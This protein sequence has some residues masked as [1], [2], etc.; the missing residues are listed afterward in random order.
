M[1]EVAIASG[2]AVIPRT[3]GRGWGDVEG[4]RANDHEVLRS[5][6]RISLGQRDDVPDGRSVKVPALSTE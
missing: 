4:E 5:G 2:E 3:L 1:L 6:R